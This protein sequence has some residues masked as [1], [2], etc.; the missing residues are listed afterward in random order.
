[1]IK[2]ENLINEFKDFIGDNGF[3]IISG[4]KAENNSV[5]G[6]VKERIT[7]CDLFVGIFTCEKT[8]SSS[9][10]ESS[11]SN[12]V[13]QESGFAIALKKDLILIVEKGI[14]KFPELQGDLEIVYF[15]RKTLHKAYTKL[16][17]M[18]IS[19]KNKMV[20]PAIKPNKANA[21]IH[22]NQ[23]D[24]QHYFPSSF[25]IISPV[26]G[27]TT[28]QTNI[29]FVWVPV[30]NATNYRLVLSCN[31]NLSNPI[32]K[33]DSNGT[34]YTYMGTL[35]PGL[36]Y[37]QVIAFRVDSIIG[38]SISG[39]FIAN[40]LNSN[41]NITSQIASWDGID[42]H[43]PVILPHNSKNIC[44]MSISGY[45][46]TMIGDFIAARKFPANSK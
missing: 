36:Y 33:Q 2:I 37:W 28:K 21:I 26:Q 3:E 7:Q 13:I 20:Q 29:P 31:S 1:M 40:D 8:I 23:P 18:L 34:A 45:A 39:A 32:I 12:W 43:Y 35:Q 30:A 15:N 17:Q 4:E 24:F 16:N 41:E 44:G 6:K 38:G 10:G 11:T 22:T 42:T 46:A 25:A 14:H 5:A 27:S 9:N 19:A